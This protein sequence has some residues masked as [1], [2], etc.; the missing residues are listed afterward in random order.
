MC[1]SYA[2][3]NAKVLQRFIPEITRPFLDD[4]PIKGCLVSQKDEIVKLDGMRQFV[5]EHM[6]SVK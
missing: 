1:G 4:I 3:W 5:W 6:N 2:I